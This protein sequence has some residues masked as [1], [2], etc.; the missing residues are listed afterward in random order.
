M[1][2][3][4]CKLL[5]LAAILY[6]TSLADIPNCVF[7]DTVVLTA[8][9]KFAN[10]SYLYEGLLV[11]PHLTAEYDYIELFEGERKPVERHVRGC[12]CKIK[13]CVKFCCHPRADMYQTSATATPQCEEVLNE[14]LKYSPLL[15]VTLRNSSRVV[16]HL[17]DEF[18]VQQGIPCEG[19][20]MLMPHVYEDDQWELFENGT[21]LRVGDAKYFSRRDYCLQAY[22]TSEEFVL[23]PMNCPVVYEEPATL[24][25]NT[26][27]MLI[28]A[29]FL[30]VTILI[31]WLIPEL[32]NLH[33]K[34]LICYLLSLAIGT[35]LIVV[36]NMQYSNLETFNCAIIGF[37]TYFFLTAVFFWLNVIC[38]DL[39]QNF[40]MT[41]GAVR[42]L[43]QRKRFLYY[44]LYAWGMP[45]LMT[46]IT[47]SLQSSNL[48]QGL[49][50][51]IGNTHCWL[52]IEDWSAMIYFHGPCLL[53]IIF[54]IVIFFLTANKIY[55]IRKELQHFSRGD[56]SQRH[57]RSQQN[58]KNLLKSFS[59]WLFF[60]MFIVMGIGWLLEIIS[61]MVGNNSKYALLF[62]FTDVYNASQG[63]IIFILLVVKKKVLLLI[64]KR[65]TKSD[66]TLQLSTRRFTKSSTTAMELSNAESRWKLRN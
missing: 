5:I 25:L 41:Q 14:E 10:G 17:L 43:T 20:Y 2:T 34:C 48:P 28:S 45:A 50:S 66:N 42:N 4:F 33:T 64:K 40:R 32:W 27:I 7:E 37:V 56:C 23:N 35:T 63:L 12:V 61:Y 16:M 15:N 47:A 11:P 19:G 30:Y 3:R 49:K 57:L 54:N 53:L 13:Q 59:V 36:V 22:N 39:W 44:S 38:F 55:E 65:F 52:K 8:S 6:Q 58:N 29:P 9:T 24:M 46:I 62:T 18:V 1:T 31:Y 51:G 60:R 21:L 26:I